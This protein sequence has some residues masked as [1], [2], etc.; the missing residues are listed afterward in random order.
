MN[1]I[2]MNKIGKKIEIMRDASYSNLTEFQ[3]YKY[4]FM[5]KYLFM[6]FVNA[7]CSNQVLN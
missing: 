3:V 1:N 7:N 5:I 2:N 4:K 6:T